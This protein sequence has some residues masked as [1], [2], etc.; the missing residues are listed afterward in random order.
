[1]LAAVIFIWIEKDNL[2]ISGLEGVSKIISR[3]FKNYTKSSG[4]FSD[5]VLSINQL[6]DGTLVF[7]HIDGL[8]FFDG[9]NF[10]KIDLK[11]NE[12]DKKS[13]FRVMDIARDIN[14][15][16]WAAISDY[17]I[18]KIL[19]NHK[20]IKIKDD[21]S[22]TD[23]YR[24]V[25]VN[26]KGDVYLATY[27]EIFK[28][29]KNRIVSIQ[30]I[31]GFGI[32]LRK[33]FFTDND[34][35]YISTISNGV[36]CIKNGKFLE[37]PFGESWKNKSTFSVFKWSTD[38]LF[39]GTS[40]GLFYYDGNSMKPA[41]LG[42][43]KIENEVLFILKDDK[44]NLWFG[45]NNGVY[46]W[47]GK[48]LRHLDPRHGL[49]AYEVER[50]AGFLD[51]KGQVWIGTSYG[52]SCYQ[53]KNDIVNQTAPKV[54]IGNLEVGNQRFDIQKPVKISYTSGQFLFNIQCISFSDEKS[55]RYRF[56]LNGFDEQWLE[57][58][59][60]YNAQIRY[61]NLKPGKYQLEI[62]AKNG[63]SDW[64]ES[65]YSANFVIL[66][67]YWQ[68]WWFILL[69]IFIFAVILYL[70]FHYLSQKRYARKLEEAVE[71]RTDQLKITEQKYR[72]LF[73]ESKDTVIISNKEGKLLDINP[74]GLQL[75]GYQSKEEL[76]NINV[77]D[78][79]Y[80]N[81]KDREVFVEELLS[82]GSLKDRGMELKTKDNQV[83][84]VRGSSTIQMVPGSDEIIFRHIIRDETERKKLEQQ[85]FQSQKMDS[86]GILAGGIAHDFNNILGSVLGYASLIK[87]KIANTDPI[88]NFVDLI[89]TSAKRA[90]ELTSRLLAFSRG[91]NFN[92]INLQMNTVVEK[93]LK[94]FE[95]N[96]DP[97]I[98]IVT[99]LKAGLPLVA[100]DAGQMEQVITNLFK[101][102]KEAIKGTGQI[103]IKT[104]AILLKNSLIGKFS[105]IPAGEYILTS[106]S[107]TGIG[108]SEEILL[109][110]FEP[111]FSTKS[112]S[113]G[114]GL[115]LAMV[116]GVVKHHKG[117]VDVFSQPGQG[118]TFR[119]YLPAQDTPVDSTEKKENQENPLRGN[120]RILIIDDE[121]A[122]RNLLKISLES[123]GYKTFSAINGLEALKIY[124]EENQQIDLLIVDMVMPKMGGR[125][126][127]EKI[128]EMNAKQKFIVSTGYSEQ[129][130]LEQIFK[131]TQ[132]QFLP[133]PFEVNQV[134]K[135]VRAVL[136]ELNH[137]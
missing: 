49:A 116:Y 17:G 11:K 132:N 8:S 50:S 87:M 88:Y 42:G 128:L 75:F 79:F 135:Q 32:S 92:L 44:N 104:N 54:I 99:E 76:S 98:K 85:I 108:M 23:E 24:S 2:W 26:S 43:S 123:Q 137:N 101:N 105:E 36:Y 37:T 100:A 30:K 95:S 83:K 134:L 19:P 78:T 120:E 47:S 18:I 64:S 119:I 90:A 93:V 130:D 70:I 81:P 10:Q 38:T 3:R 124:R 129:S 69:L 117:F 20:I 41:V 126:T 86:I 67:P 55:I 110:I 65:S 111:F 33:L 52:V 118:T 21:V 114:A 59:Y 121:D 61:T 57:N 68:S 15:S 66:R 125:E 45:T 127:I 80:F 102:A 46:L 5:E 56:K 60:F 27:K 53:E 6:P 131:M 1:M 4:L 39:V 74:A 34:D 48:N 89:E 22:H 106:I 9:H 71:I 58:P 13:K 91:G 84:F 29:V 103:S 122:L 97:S 25:A 107:D 82:K 112:K 133:K 115:G 113:K 73:M 109:K 14:G 77:K 136:D 51:K 12:A 62:Q 72:S 16:L 35:L 63:L 7:G 94:N 96:L 28:I 40:D 31:N